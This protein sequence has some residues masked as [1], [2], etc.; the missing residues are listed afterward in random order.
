MEQTP[1][2]V[3]VNY[4]RKITDSRKDP[5]EN[6]RK[7]RAEEEET[8]EESNNNFPSMLGRLLGVARYL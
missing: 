5:A 8:E 4:N 2:G 6:E 7:R 3:V 1:K